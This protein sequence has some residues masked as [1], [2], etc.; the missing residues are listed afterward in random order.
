MA[1]STQYIGL[2]D[3]A[4][5]FL[6]KNFE[7]TLPEDDN[8]VIGLCDEVIQLTSY[9]SKNQ[10]YLSAREVVQT[11]PWSSGPMIFTHIEVELLDKTKV[12]W[13]SWEVN[14]SLSETNQEVDYENGWYYV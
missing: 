11:I 4:E 12:L 10:N 14:E 7:L 8:V 3:K 2:N 5:D 9:V 1:R 13:Y 6:D